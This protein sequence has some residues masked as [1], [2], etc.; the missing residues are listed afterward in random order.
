M[1]EAYKQL[2][3]SNGK[4]STLPHKDKL[5]QTKLREKEIKDA[6][7]E[8]KH[9]EKEEKEQERLEAAEAAR[10][11]RAFHHSSKRYAKDEREKQ[12]KEEHEKTGFTCE[13]GVWRCR[14]CN[15]VSTH[16]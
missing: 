9:A 10:F 15:P 13:H 11:E 2:L 14:I 8:K 4:H 12:K 3:T 1:A 7:R 5:L 16:K 6:L